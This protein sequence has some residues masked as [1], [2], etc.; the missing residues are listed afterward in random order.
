MRRLAR[1]LPKEIREVRRG[2]THHC[3]DIVETDFVCQVS[4][5]VIDRVP[6]APIAIART[7]YDGEGFRPGYAGMLPGEVDDQLLAKDVD[8][9]A[10]TGVSATHLAN[11][12]SADGFREW[13]W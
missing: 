9:H 6:Q 12:L 4:F 1:A 7:A 8:H 2:Q 13:V 11:H 10:R 3:R 5:E